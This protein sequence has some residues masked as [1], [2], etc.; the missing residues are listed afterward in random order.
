MPRRGPFRIA[1]QLLR[2]FDAKK[3]SHKILLEEDYAFSIGATRLVSSR[4]I[5]S[6]CDIKPDTPKSSHID[7][8]YLNSIPQQILRLNASKALISIYVCSDGLPYFASHILPKMK[9]RFTLVSGD[10]DLSISEAKL[11]DAFL[12]IATHPL[13]HTW[14]AQNLDTVFPKLEP[15]PIGLD[16]HS[17][18]S[19]PK[20]W[21]GGFLLPHL[22]EAQLRKIM[23]ESN[24]PSSRKPYA[25]CDWLE[26]LG[27][28]DRQ[29]CLNQIQRDCCAIQEERTS[30]IQT[31]V[32][33]SHYQFV[34]SPRGEGIDCHRTW[35]AIALG[36]IPIVTKSHL[37]QLFS[38][39]PVVQLNHWGDL[40]ESLMQDEL[41]KISTKKLNFSL[42]LLSHWKDRIN[43]SESRI[44]KTYDTGINEFQQRFF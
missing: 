10:S 17:T 34:V 35:E 41:K 28:G 6:V 33:Q 16:F 25:Y 5:V 24:I 42:I 30:R 36:C 13:L 18:W 38:A 11:G 7:V 15:L 31:W 32:N 22:Q 29:E 26:N 20:I 3:R 14:F 21:G 19:D 40:D 8:E 37:S 12:T 44:A 9:K 23:I 43:G 2:R 39:L 4:G 1:G 27:R